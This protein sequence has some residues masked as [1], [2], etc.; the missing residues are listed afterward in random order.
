[1]TGHWNPTFLIDSDVY[2]HYSLVTMVLK[3]CQD[4]NSRPCVFDMVFLLK[5]SVQIGNI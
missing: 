5:Y 4:I 2:Y 3:E 1:M